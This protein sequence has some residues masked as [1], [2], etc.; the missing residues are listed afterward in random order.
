MG[1]D[2]D[3]DIVFGVGTSL[4]EV[5]GMLEWKVQRVG[6]KEWDITHEGYSRL[7]THFDLFLPS[8]PPDL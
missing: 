5:L 3:E 7:L 1:G 6:W 8:A 2:V 4:V